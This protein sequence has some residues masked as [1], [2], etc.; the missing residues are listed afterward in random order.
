MLVQCCQRAV[1]MSLRY[2]CNVLLPRSHACQRPV[3]RR[4][5][6]SN[7][8]ISRSCPLATRRLPPRRVSLLSN[9]TMSR[10]RRPAISP[11]RRSCLKLERR[12][13]DLFS[14]FADAEGEK[15]SRAP[16]RCSTG[17]IPFRY[18]QSG[19]GRPS[20]VPGIPQ[21]TSA[22]L[23]DPGLAARSIAMSLRAMLSPLVRAGRP[24]QTAKF[25]DSV[26]QLK[27]SLHTVAIALRSIAAA[28]RQPHFV[29]CRAYAT[30]TQCSLPAGG[31]PLPGGSG[32]PLGINCIFH[33]VY[34]SH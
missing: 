27:C 32:Y 2:A 3:L 28:S 11:S 1:R 19:G 8:I 7:T 24:W 13:P 31:Q 4:V 10:L 34:V 16:G 17:F 21:Y 23:V 6:A 20:Q 18:F 33:H 29:S 26:T 5:S 9:A 30:T 12:Y 15:A 22:P 25:R 14:C